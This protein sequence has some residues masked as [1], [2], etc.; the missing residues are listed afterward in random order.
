MAAST[1]KVLRSIHGH[2]TLPTIGFNLMVAADVALMMPFA[3]LDQA[4][5]I[6]RHVAMATSTEMAQSG[7]RGFATQAA[8]A[9]LAV[10]VEVAPLMRGAP[11]H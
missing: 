5:A 6:C 4:L 11:G 9:G 8:P 3:P 2:A 1:G 7:I 10:A